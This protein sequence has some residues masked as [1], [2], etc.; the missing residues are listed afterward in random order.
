MYN[1]DDKPFFYNIAGY[2]F[3]LEEIKHGLLRNNIKPPNRFMRTLGASDEKLGILSDFFNHKILFVCLDFPECLE[4][5]DSFEGEDE[6]ELENELNQF[7]EG[8]L[9]NKVHI[10]LD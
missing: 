7:V 9:E 1:T 5:I 4:Q 6:E 3:S 8:I 2:N 10:D